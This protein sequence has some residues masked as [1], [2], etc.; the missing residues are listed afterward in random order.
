MYLTAHAVNIAAATR[1]FVANASPNS[2]MS[3]KRDPA[4]R[5]F[6]RG[7]GRIGLRSEQ[8]PT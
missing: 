4:P 2:G 3:R 8:R 6:L 5:D 1:L 7:G